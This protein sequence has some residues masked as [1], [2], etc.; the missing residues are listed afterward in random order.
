MAVRAS[1]TFFSS[2]CFSGVFR[3]GRAFS[4]V[5]ERC[6]SLLAAAAW[7]PLISWAVG[8][9]VHHEAHRCDPGRRPAP[10]AEP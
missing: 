3:K 8:D 9:A 2:A 5:S 4:M 7:I 1:S 10:K 6:A